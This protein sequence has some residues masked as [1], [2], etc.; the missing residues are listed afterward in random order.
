MRHLEGTERGVRGVWAA[1]AR[2]L[3][4]AHPAL[5]LDPRRVAS[6]S[7]SWV[8]AALR[9]V[10]PAP[11]AVSVLHDE[12]LHPA[13]PEV[14]AFAALHRDP[15]AEPLLL[16]AARLESQKG[17]E[18]AVRALGRLVGEH[19]VSARLALAGPGDEQTR[20]D[21]R[22]LAA[23]VGIADRIELHGRLEPARLRELVARAHVWLVPSVWEEPAPTTCVEA[24]LARVPVV[25]SRVGGIPELVR[26]G[27]DGLLFAPGDEEDC[28]R[29]VA[30]TLTD[31]EATA[32]RVL[33]AR[34]RA[35]ALR[36]AP[37]LER[38]D[39]FLERAVAAHRERYGPPA[40]SARTASV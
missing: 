11:P 24:A 29:A 23:A 6:A 20:R 8:S 22:R 38:T 39:V 15:A 30:A 13:T 5:R 10:S 16:Y 25:A 33:R 34:E 1:G 7:V 4:A 28:A 2:M 36:F 35:D 12:V 21:L 17:A 31:R 40:S 32:R 37:Y 18:V 9:R 26:D 19:G 27:Q 3:N 14:E